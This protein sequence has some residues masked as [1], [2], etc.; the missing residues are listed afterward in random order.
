MLADSAL[1][2][3][4]LPHLHHLTLLNTVPSVA[5]ALLQLQALPPNLTTLTLAGEALSSALVEQVYHHSWVTHLYNLYGPSED[6]TYSTAYRIPLPPAAGA[7]P[8]IGTPIAHSQV[9]L[10]DAQLQLVPLGVVGEIYLAGA[11]LAR[12]YWKRAEL[13]AERF[14]PN[15]FGVGTRLYRTGDRGRYRADGCIEYLGRLDQQVKLRGVRI[16]LGEIESLLAQHPAVQQAI[17]TLST[18]DHRPPQ[19]VA[20]IIPTA[21][22]PLVRRGSRAASPLA[23]HTYLQTR[24]PAHMLPAQITLHETFPL[25]PNGKIDR[26]RLATLV[27]ESLQTPINEPPQTPVE[28]ELHRIWQQLLGC[29][30]INRHD[31]FFALGGD[32]IL[33]IQMIAKASQVGLHFS[34]K[35]VFQHQ[36]IAALAAFAAPTAAIT[37]PQQILTGT[38]PLTPIQHWFFEQNFAEMHH[39][40]QAVL[41]EV[42]Q[43]V[44][45][46]WLEQALQQLLN[47][48]DSLRLR[49]QRTEFGWRQEY[50]AASIAPL[51]WIDLSQL[52]EPQQTQA[53]EMTATVLQ[54]SLDISTLPLRIAFFDRGQRSGRLLLI[55]HHLVVDGISWR[56]LLSDL[57]HL[58]QQFSQGKPAE[59]PP[60]TSAFRQWAE[61]LHSYQPSADELNYWHTQP[62]TP[63]PID[64]PCHDIPAHNR[65]ADLETV[66]VALSAADTQALLQTAPAAYQTQINDLLLTA[67][68]QAFSTWTGSATLLIELESHGRE[69]LFTN[70]DLSRTVGWFTTL[71]PV[72]LDLGQADTTATAIKIIKEQLRAIPQN[73]IGYGIWRYL[74]PSQASPPPAAKPQVRFNYLGQI[75]ALFSENPLFGL[76]PEAIGQFRSPSS[77]RDVLLEVNALIR[78]HQLRLDW[79][80]SRALHHRRT[81][82]TLAEQYLIALRQIIQHCLSPE[83][84]GYTPSDFPLMAIDQAELDELLAEL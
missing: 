84:G 6:T 76:A 38:V 16:E 8:P 25:T 68:V 80:Y 49:F 7:A 28:Q 37:A 29:E 62:D 30:T 35:Q 55:L 23:L 59:L 27:P 4:Q 57:H 47:H 3:A 17:V 70:I 75:D 34:P 44:G 79:N 66:S 9:Y 48:H 54:A 20:H 14:V 1:P 64:H 63:L 10:L 50:A 60:K 52:S 40:N 71:F 36:T 83:A 33:V 13:T 43:P 81:I 56:I 32:S 74:H 65:V 82:A 61:A 21:P 46:E 67:F 77:H 39:W 45:R 2:L 53:I 72:W 42:R 12:G 69:D 41:L 11:G 73:G 15:P 18:L 58:Y 5:Q 51:H 22:S 26:A 19:L 24:L 31:N 78:D